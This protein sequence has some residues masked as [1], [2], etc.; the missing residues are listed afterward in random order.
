MSELLLITHFCVCADVAECSGSVDVC[1]HGTCVERTGDYS[2][3]CDAGYAG[4]KCD[5]CKLQITLPRN[6]RIVI[7]LFHAI[8]KI[9]LSK[10]HGN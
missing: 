10:L 8:I 7:S 3:N 4:K 1:K 5:K 2:C 9:L 6:G